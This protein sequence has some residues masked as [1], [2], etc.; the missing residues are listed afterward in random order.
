MLL[1][2]WIALLLL[3]A[4]GTFLSTCL[5]ARFIGEVIRHKKIDDQSHPLEIFKFIHTPNNTSGGIW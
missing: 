1:I 2:F 3:V 4:L 5:Y